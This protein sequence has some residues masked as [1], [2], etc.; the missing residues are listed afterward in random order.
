MEKKVKKEKKDFGF[1]AFENEDGKMTA[2]HVWPIV[3]DN[4]NWK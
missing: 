2:A 4:I 3:K 1:L